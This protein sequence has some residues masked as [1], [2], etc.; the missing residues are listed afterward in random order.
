MINI[1][2]KFFSYIQKTD[3]N[4]DK[5][6]GWF[7]HT[8]FHTIHYYHKILIQYIYLCFVSNDLVKIGESILD[9]IEFLIK[10]KLKTSKDK[11]Y[12][13]YVINKDIPGIKEKQEIKKNILTK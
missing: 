5:L 8:N 3:Y 4:Y 1:Y 12:I 11:K 2:F 6:S 9:Y 7:M 10:F 13:L